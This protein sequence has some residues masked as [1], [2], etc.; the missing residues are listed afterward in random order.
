LL[1][2]HLANDGMAIVATHHELELKDGELQ[3]LDLSDDSSAPAP[4]GY[5]S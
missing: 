2:E 3:R 4:A 5:A 1:K